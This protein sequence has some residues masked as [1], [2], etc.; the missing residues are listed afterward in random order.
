M[1]KFIKKIRFFCILFLLCLPFWAEAAMQSTSYVIYENV[2]HNFDGPVISNVSQSVSGNSAIITW[3][4][5]VIADAF[6]VYDTTN[7][8]TASKEQGSSVKSSTNH[9]VAVTGLSYSTTYYYQVKSTRINGGVTVEGTIRSFTTDAEPVT[10]T[11]PT[12]PS[13]GGGGIL[14]IDKTDKKPPTISDVL[15]SDI[16][17][18]SS[19]I[20]WKTDEKATSFVEYGSGVGLGSTYGQW[21]STT[22]HRVEM[23]NLEANMIY[24]FRVLS[25]DGWGNVGRS[26][27]SQFTTKSGL[28]GEEATTTPGEAVKPEEQAVINEATRRVIEFLNRLFPEVS[29]NQI[30]A[31]RIFSIG[32]L[33]E[34]A[35]LMPTPVL[36]GE[37]KVTV[38]ATQATI[39][40]TTDI[41]A[42]SLVA[43]APADKYNPNSNE[44]YQ[45]VVGDAENMVSDHTVTVYGLTA[46]TEYH[47]QLRSKT[48]I[49]PTARSRDFTF[50][51][52]LEEL[53]I[54]S[55]FSQIIDGQT[56]VFKWVTNKEADSTVRFAPYHDNV[57]AVDESK[58]VIDNASTIIHEIKITDFQ[59]GVFYDVELMSVDSQGNLASAKLDHFATS[60]DDLP[61]DISHIKADSTVFL[62]QGDKIQTIISWLTNEPAT[63]KIYYQEGVQAANVQLKESTN[64]NTNYTKEHVMVITKFKP[65]VVYS[66]RVE[67]IDSGG[68]ITLSPVHTFMTAK[69][70][71]SIIQIIIR[72]LEQT[73]GWTKKLTGG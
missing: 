34:F 58:T 8:F 45:Q 26:E 72:I 22:E 56:A 70:K 1:N 67:S 31:N 51:T 6:V 10:P 2:M 29:L 7:P 62:D 55:F 36:S 13:S 42:N 43:I 61:P 20:T 18:E 30:G 15:V 40:W 41:N 65:G 28:P 14:I 19:V 21:A 50:R 16:T 3:D 5:N 12:P 11:P 68:N 59:Q 33:K 48:E 64:L 23:I 37:P 17:T 44:P 32:S 25:S 54:T 53:T 63:S 24:N 47:F 46:D 52:N 71:E 9:S 66:F 38:G 57:L 27:V 49:G 35:G 73:F 60:K 69:K 39:F 4:T